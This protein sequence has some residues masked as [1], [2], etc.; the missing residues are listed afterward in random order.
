MTIL[1][2]DVVGFTT[3][4][5]GI[6]PIDVFNLLNEM[7]SVFDELTVKHGVFKVRSMPR[8]VILVLAEELRY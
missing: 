1:F 5:S 6:Q 2:T 7:Y 8:T 4:C 3:I